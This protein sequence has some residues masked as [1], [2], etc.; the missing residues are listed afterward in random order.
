MNNIPS[1][2]IHFVRPTAGTGI[3]AV[4]SGA[5]TVVSAGAAVFNPAVA[6][7]NFN[8][9][10][11]HARLTSAA[12]ANAGCNFRMGTLLVCLSVT[13][14]YSNMRMGTASAI[15][16]Q[17]AFWG[18]TASTTQLVANVDPSS[19]T[20]IIGAG[21]DSGDTTL[22]IL[23]NDAAGT[24]TKV[25]LGANFPVDATTVFE[26]ELTNALGSSDV[27]Y[28]VTNL[29]TGTQATGTLSTNLPA[30]TQ[31][32]ATQVLAG[33]GATGGAALL[34]LFHMYLGYEP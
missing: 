13:G 3:L 26:I 30:T 15:N 11:Y 33:N 9:S 18:L 25:N 14:F 21:Y 5:G 10:H 6:T 16:T 29:S 32:L 17:R 4:G 20:N 27:T 7:T 8:T 12:G 22:H 1:K 24:A 31:F 2:F 28:T 19:Y 34:E 23:H